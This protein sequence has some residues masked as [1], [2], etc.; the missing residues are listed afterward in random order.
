MEMSEKARRLEST[1]ELLRG[2]LEYIDS[3]LEPHLEFAFQEDPGE[4]Y[5]DA[6][7]KT[8]APLVESSEKVYKHLT[9]GP[10]AKDKEY[11]EVI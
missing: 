8:L 1:M 9:S 5:C 4:V 3:T 10:M 2:R 11:K 7:L 6:W